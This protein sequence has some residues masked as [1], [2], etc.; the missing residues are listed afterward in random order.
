[1]CAL[2]CYGSTYHGHK[3][4]ACAG[5]TRLAHGPRP[6]SRQSVPQREIETG[7]WARSTC[8]ATP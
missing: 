8:L 2:P 3:F 5:Q 6:K 4:G 7:E 1:L